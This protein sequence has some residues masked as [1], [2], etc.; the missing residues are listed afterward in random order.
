[1]TFLDTLYEAKA[2]MIISSCTAYARMDIHMLNM[3]YLFVTIFILVIR[4]CY[5]IITVR[6]LICFDI[7]TRH[8]SVSLSC[9]G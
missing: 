1:M 7:V 9:K 2:L 5:T 4:P 3:Y 6:H 8:S